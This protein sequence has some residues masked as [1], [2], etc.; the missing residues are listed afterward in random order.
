[1]FQFLR[2]KHVE[3]DLHQRCIDELE[4]LSLLKE[5]NITPDLMIACCTKLL[6][7]KQ[8]LGE[9]FK[10]RCL[11]ITNYYS[12]MSDGYICIPWNWKL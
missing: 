12:I 1:M 9:C 4:L 7:H 5:D 8:Q 3:R 6:E 11:W 10:G 2:N